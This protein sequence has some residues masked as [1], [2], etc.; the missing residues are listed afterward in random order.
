MGFRNCGLLREGA[1]PGRWGPWVLRLGVFI[2]FGILARPKPCQ[3]FTGLP[4]PVGRTIIP[5]GW[6]HLLYMAIGKI[7]PTER[8]NAL[9]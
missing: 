6:G 9:L 3:P 2:R 1:A 8:F 4:Q 5:G 7:S